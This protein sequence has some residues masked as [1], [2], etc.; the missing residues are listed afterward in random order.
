M[1]KLLL[2]TLITTAFN[3]G[4]NA[5]SYANNWLS[6]QGTGGFLTT[7]DMCTDNAGNLYKTGRFQLSPDF[8]PGAGVTTITSNG[9]GDIFIQK[10]DPSGNLLWVKT[11][12]GAGNDYGSGIAVD[13]LGNVYVTGG[14]EDTVDFDPSNSGGVDKVSYGSVDAFVLK[15]NSSGDYQWIKTGGGTG[16]DGANSIS[17]DNS[18]NVYVSGVYI[19]SATF[20]L[21][22]GGSNITSNG[23]NDA[24]VWKLS[25]TGSFTWVKSIG[26]TGAETSYEIVVDGA[27]NSYVGGKAKSGADFDPGAAVVTKTNNGGYDA[28]I[29]SLDASGNFQWANS[30]GGSGEDGVREIILSTSN[31]IY[32]SGFFNSTVDFD[33]DGGGLNISALSSYELFIQKLDVNGTFSWAKAF[34][35]CLSSSGSCLKETSTGNLMFCGGFTG[36]ADFDPNVGT[37]IVVSNGDVDVFFAEIDALGNYVDV[38]T[39]GGSNA[40]W[41]NSLVL[42]NDNVIL[43]GSASSNFDFNPN[44]A[45]LTPGFKTDYTAKYI[46]CTSSASTDVQ[47]A[48]GSYMWIDGNTYSTNNTTATHVLTNANGCDSV[49]TLNLTINNSTTG[50]DT[51]VSCGSY[52]WIN[53]FTYNSSNSTATHVLTNANGCDSVVTLNLT[54][55]NATMGTDI[56]NSCTPITWI[57]GNTCTSSNTSA[58]HTLVN[59]IGCDSVVTLD[60]TILTVD[61]TVSQVGTVLTANT[62]GANYQWLDCNNGN[63]NIAGATGQTYTATANGSYAVEVAQNGCAETSACIVVNGV[64]LLENNLSQQV[65]LY[66]NPTNG[67]FYIDLGEAFKQAEILIFDLNGRVV[68]EKIVTKTPLINLNFKATNGVYFV[69]LITDDE[70]AVVK[71]IKK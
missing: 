6:Q 47:I 64:G 34:A 46:L 50:I 67:N 12:G 10:L 16:V 52:L 43:T 24:F 25:A 3:V 23:S 9:V 71:L 18:A 36:I 44:G 38:F 70:Q 33:P 4:A 53:G 2:I 39:M 45:A 68:F 5:Q 11:V 26:G 30:F 37:Q 8:E 19:G 14:F 60:L 42:D 54:I 21:L 69:K 58:T 55:N 1:K 49:I 32:V 27:G 29:V 65:N 56:I 31:E 59:S 62:T 17:L 7:T 63:T 57:D 61:A 48:C 13:V 20:D 40:D 15:L 41:G 66:P 28:F 35:G 51:Q 22:A